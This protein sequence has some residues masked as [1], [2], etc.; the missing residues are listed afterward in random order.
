[1]IFRNQHLAMIK[2][3]F[4]MKSCIDKDDATICS[5]NERDQLDDTM[6]EKESFGGVGFF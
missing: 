3:V 1:M 4:N 5:T 6:S 2:D